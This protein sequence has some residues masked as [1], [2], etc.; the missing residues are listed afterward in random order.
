MNVHNGH[1]ISMNIHLIFSLLCEMPNFDLPFRF[2]GSELNSMLVFYFISYVMRYDKRAKENGSRHFLNI[3]CSKNMI[4]EYVK[5]C[6]F[7]GF[8]KITFEHGE[9]QS[10][11]R[12]H[13]CR[14]LNSLQPCSS[15]D[16]KYSEITVSQ[17]LKQRPNFFTVFPFLRKVPG[18]TKNDGR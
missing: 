3:L 7:S 14:E 10:W 9:Q 17:N 15:R 2:E 5:K 1:K 18:K 12:E 4:F 11:Q 8:S 16:Q 13:F 6:I